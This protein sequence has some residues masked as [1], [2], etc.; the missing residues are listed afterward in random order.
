[1]AFSGSIQKIWAQFDSQKPVIWQTGWATPVQ[2]KVP[3]GKSWEL[4]ALTAA[5]YPE[6]GATG[7]ATAVT[8]KNEF[9]A[10]N[11][12]LI[13]ALSKD[14]SREFSFNMGAMP[15]RIVNVNRCKFW[16]N[17]AY[18]NTPPPSAQR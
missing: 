9:D 12:A 15:N 17:T 4:H 5:N 18:T 3:V 14:G 7:W 16:W 8:I 10:G 6:V 2:V 11:A 13:P 1:M